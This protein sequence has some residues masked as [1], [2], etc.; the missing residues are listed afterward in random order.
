M[1]LSPKTTLWTLAGAM[2]AWCGHA[3]ADA[4]ADPDLSLI[5]EIVVTSQRR[6]QSVLDHAGNVAWVDGQRLDWIRPQHMQE[7]MN[8]VPGAWVARG[9]GQEH[10]AALRSPLLGGGGGCGGVLPLEDG[11]PIRPPG[12]CNVNLFLEL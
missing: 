8:L 3:Q 6:E 2:L 12:F 4:E 5:D 7:V 1:K 9:S 11:I 10:Q